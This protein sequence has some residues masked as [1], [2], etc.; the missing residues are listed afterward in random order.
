MSRVRQRM[1]S[2]QG[3]SLLRSRG[4][5]SFELVLLRTRSRTAMAS[6]RLK[7]RRGAAHPSDPLGQRLG[8]TPDLKSQNRTLPFRVSCGGHYDDYLSTLLATTISPDLSGPCRR[9]ILWRLSELGV[10]LSQVQSHHCN[11]SGAESDCLDIYAWRQ[12]A[13]GEICL[14]GMADNC[15]CDSYSDQW[16]R[17]HHRERSHHQLLTRIDLGLIPMGAARNSNALSRPAADFTS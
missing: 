12:F 8:H 16:L 11:I 4:R 5:T 13:G 15:L 7:H 9:R 14:A 3:L 2:Y 10:A 17:S 1:P 6:G